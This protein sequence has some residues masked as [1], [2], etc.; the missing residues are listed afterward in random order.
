[1]TLACMPSNRAKDNGNSQVLGNVFSSGTISP[2]KYYREAKMVVGVCVRVGER[3]LA[4]EMW[5]SIFS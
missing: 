1:M 4:R 5:G 3:K 2:L